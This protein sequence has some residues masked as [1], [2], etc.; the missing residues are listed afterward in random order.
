MASAQAAD[1][2]AGAGADA[3]ADVRGG[4][5]TAAGP[6][7]GAAI[8]AG[9]AV[10]AATALDTATGAVARA[11]HTAEA[12]AD[13]TALAPGPVSADAVEP[14]ADGAT[15]AAE[16]LATAAASQEATA[17]ARALS[18]AI[19]ASVQVLYAAGGAAARPSELLDAAATVAAAAEVAAVAAVRAA[20]AGAPTEATA[21]VWEDL[22]ANAFATIN[23]TIVEAA[24]AVQQRGD[25]A[26][27]SQR[28]VD[29][30]VALVSKPAMPNSFVLGALNALREVALSRDARDLA[31]DLRLLDTPNLITSCVARMRASPNNDDAVVEAALSLFAITLSSRDAAARMLNVPSFVATCTARAEPGN[32]EAVVVEALNVLYSLVAASPGVGC[33]LSFRP[34]DLERLLGTLVERADVGTLSPHVSLGALRVLMMMSYSATDAERV[35]MLRASPRLVRMCVTRAGLGATEEVAYVTLLVLHGLAMSNANRLPMFRTPG[36]VATCVG[37]AKSGPT[38]EI[39]ETACFTLGALA[40]DLANVCVPLC[41]EPDLVAIAVFLARSTENHVRVRYAGMGLLQNLCR[42]PPT[43]IAIGTN[44]EAMRALIEGLK[45]VDPVNVRHA[46]AT[47]HNISR[48]ATLIPEFRQSV[49]LV[50]LLTSLAAGD[51]VKEICILATMALVNCLGE[52]A[53][54]LEALRLS[55]AN[56]SGVLNAM[57]MALGESVEG[58][59]MNLVVAAPLQVLRL[60]VLV[61]AYREYL[62]GNGLHGLVA[63]ALSKA[64]REDKEEAALYGVVVARRVVAEDQTLLRTFKADA[65][66]TEA[67]ARVC[68]RSG[69]DWDEARAAGDELLGLMG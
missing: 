17:A 20:T 37:L 61:R 41:S 53:A 38:V 57:R 65:V 12:A 33:G 22:V 43:R 66:L 27:F 67:L 3:G 8:A 25:P 18:A 36:L 44:A 21:A 31:H 11:P 69:T 58:M 45:C 50:A 26:P 6:P 30:L 54:G 64:A 55:D 49:Q 60:L 9:A 59:T 51:A 28:L 13:A 68:A 4:A 52:N 19:G 62:V 10:A 42:T 40:L 47:A 7:A 46:A 14:F 15:T 32:S 34:S 63:R 16:Q 1:A 29:S 2:G 23:G 5:G 48:S 35:V 24:Q 39:V 56:L